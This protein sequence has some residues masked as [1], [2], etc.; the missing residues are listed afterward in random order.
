MSQ[1][2]FSKNSNLVEVKHFIYPRYDQQIE[3]ELLEHGITHLFSFGNIKIND[4]NVIG[5]G[6]TGVIALLDEKRVVKIRRTDAPKETLKIEAEIQQIAYPSSPK[7][8][9]YGNNFIVMEYVNNAR[10]LNKSDLKFLPD[11][12]VRARYLEEVKIEHHE[13]SR[14]WKNVLVNDQR[15]YIIDYDSASIKENAFNVNKILSAFGYN[16]LAVKYKRGLISFEEL[17]AFFTGK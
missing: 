11:L 6:K 1:A 2:I 13:I 14:P 5:K 16:E 7:V 10:P 15:T 8:Y 3:K 12:L 4:V 17:L 9:F